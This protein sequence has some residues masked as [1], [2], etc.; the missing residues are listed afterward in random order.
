LTEF[1]VGG[2]S[3]AVTN[4]YPMPFHI[5]LFAIPNREIDTLFSNTQVLSGTEIGYDE[6]KRPFN[7]RQYMFGYSLQC[8]RFLDSLTGVKGISQTISESLAS[9]AREIPIPED[10]KVLFPQLNLA[11]S[12][13]PTFM[14]HGTNDTAVL[15]DESRYFSKQLT[16][17]GV[18][19]ILVEVQGGDHGF[20]FGVKADDADPIYYQ[21]RRI[22]PWLKTKLE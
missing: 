4:R 3:E 7:P 8:G 14:T 15:V 18:E 22:G 11:A 21:L 20:D 16:E 13:P 19:N 2:R 5:P 9:S 6:Q 1:H 12:F 10:A 17:L